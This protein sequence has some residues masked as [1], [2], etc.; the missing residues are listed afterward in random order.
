MLS[1]T[2]LHLILR[3]ILQGEHCYDYFHTKKLRLRE[4]KI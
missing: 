3:A 4:I 1:D 2:I